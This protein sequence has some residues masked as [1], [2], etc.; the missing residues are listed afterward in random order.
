MVAIILFV[1]FA[2]TGS[3]FLFRLLGWSLNKKQPKPDVVHEDVVTHLLPQPP[4]NVEQELPSDQVQLAID[5]ERL[6]IK[7]LLHDDTIQRITAIKLKLEFLLLSPTK[8]TKERYG[9]GILHDLERTINAIRYF[10]ED[11]DDQDIAGNTLITLLYE[12]ESK[13][14]NFHFIQVFVTEDQNENTFPLTTKEKTELLYI[15][16]EA[17]QNTIKYSTQTQFHINVTW[18]KDGLFIEAEDPGYG[19]PPFAKKGYGL[20]SIQARAKTIGASMEVF[21]PRRQGIRIV[22]FLPKSILAH[23][24]EES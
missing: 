2:I 23:S 22:T 14:K 4:P 17:M 13:F 6:R 15:V 19:M 21:T 11:I 3:Y 10:I 20:D 1:Y 7:R 9:G 18:Q 24:D 8:A 12:L 5:E 16:K